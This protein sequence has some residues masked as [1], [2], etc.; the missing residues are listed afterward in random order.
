MTQSLKTQQYKLPE[1]E[2]QMFHSTIGNIF[3]CNT[4]TKTHPVCICAQP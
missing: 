4:N 2:H 1:L 3:G